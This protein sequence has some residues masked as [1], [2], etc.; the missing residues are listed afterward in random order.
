VINR[1]FDVYFPAA[2]ATALE[3]RNRT[4][5]V[6]LIWT[7][8]SWLVSLYTNCTHPVLFEPIHCPTPEQLSAFNEAVLRGDITWC[9]LFVCNPTHIFAGS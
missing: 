1:Y 2:V 9:V 7:T 6:R 8:H 3:L 4:D 5:N